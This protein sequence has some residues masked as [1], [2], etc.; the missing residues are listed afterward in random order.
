MGLD[1]SQALTA[2]LTVASGGGPFTLELRGAF[3]AVT[4]TLD[5]SPVTVQQTGG[6]I[7]LALDLPAGDHQL[8]VTP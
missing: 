6:G 2:K 4:A 5:G 7:E 1:P 3:G 8:V